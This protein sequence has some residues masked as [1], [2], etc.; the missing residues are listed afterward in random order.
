[1]TKV[2]VTTRI[3]VADQVEGWVLVGKGAGV[4]GFGSPS[5][6]DLLI[7]EYSLLLGS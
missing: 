4:L 6:L 7:F 5:F 3:L 1:M 2:L